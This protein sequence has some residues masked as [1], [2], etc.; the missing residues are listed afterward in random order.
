M[1]NLKT[2]PGLL[3]VI[4]LLLC[5]TV[6]GQIARSVS[7]MVVSEFKTSSGDI[8]VILPDD[9]RAGDVITGTVT[10]LPDGKNEKDK[11]K[12]MEKLQ[13]L[14]ITFSGSAIKLN[15]L[16]KEENNRFSFTMPT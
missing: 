6:F 14:A 4:V 12:N 8:T 9:I 13:E 11:K 5:N 3:L 16:L 1:R 10:A 7:G 15:D 2:I